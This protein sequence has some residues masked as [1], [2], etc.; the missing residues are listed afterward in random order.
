MNQS[1]SRS[2]NAPH[3]VFADSVTFISLELVMEIIADAAGGDLG[4]QIGCTGDVAV[5]IN[6]DFPA[7]FG[8]DEQDAIGLRRALQVQQHGAVIAL[9]HPQGVPAS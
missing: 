6:H 8:L 9:L 3:D 5:L 2:M 4:D 7:E 1:I